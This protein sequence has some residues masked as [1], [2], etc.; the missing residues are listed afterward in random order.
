M[1]RGCSTSRIDRCTPANTVGQL[2]VSL[3]SHSLS[4]SVPISFRYAVLLETF[5]H[6]SYCGL[7]ERSTEQRLPL[8]Q[9]DS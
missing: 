9:R 1:V 7:V 4:E 6:Y 8:A 3:A 2:L 5:F